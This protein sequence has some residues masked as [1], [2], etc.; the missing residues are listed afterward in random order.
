MN[1]SPQIV[2]DFKNEYWVMMELVEDNMAGLSL[3]D[4]EKARQLLN[5]IYDTWMEIC[6]GIANALERQE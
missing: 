6:Y 3:E 2:K 5:S 1:K 4:E